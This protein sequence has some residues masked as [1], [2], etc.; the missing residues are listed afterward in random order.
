MGL[1]DL[2][3]PDRTSVSIPVAKLVVHE[4]FEDLNND[5]ALLKLA[6]PVQFTEHIGPVC[7]LGPSRSVL[8]YTRR[9]KCYALGY[10]LR[11][12]LAVATRLQKLAVTAMAPSECNGDRLN[13]LELRRG[14]VCVGPAESKVGSACQVS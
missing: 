3:M 2:L 7:L 6:R 13:Q 9:R 10:G 14:A 12:D 8:A 5:L 1:Y 11:A 4:D